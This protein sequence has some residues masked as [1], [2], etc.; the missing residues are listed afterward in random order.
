MTGYS[1]RIVRETIPP[2]QLA[3]TEHEVEQIIQQQNK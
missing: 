3:K 2:E 1:L